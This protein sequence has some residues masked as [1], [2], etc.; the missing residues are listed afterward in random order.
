[1]KKILTLIAVMSM[2]ITLASAQQIK[3]WKNNVCVKQMS[4]SEVDYITFE[5]DTPTTPD[6]YQLS[7]LMGTWMITHSKGTR[8]ENGQVTKS[9]DED[10]ELEFNCLVIDNSKRCIFME[11]SLD[12]DV[13]HEDGVNTFDIVN[14]KPVITS[15]DFSDIEIAS[16]GNG[17]MTLKYAFKDAESNL[18]K[19][20]TDTMKRISQRTDVLKTSTNTDPAR[21]ETL[22][23]L[24]A[25]DLVGTWLI[26]NDKHEDEATDNV[27]DENVESEKNYYVIFSDKLGF[28]EYSNESNSWHLDSGEY[29]KY[30][31]KD[32]KFS[33]PYSY[34]MEYDGANKAKVFVVYVDEKGSNIDT[35]PHIYTLQ[36]VSRNTD[37]ITYRE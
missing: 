19:R 18:I 9:W 35:K 3:F 25:N 7:D 6:S 5:E 37:Y 2:Y 4:A 24:N 14:G 10:V 30:A 11:G 13:W 12:D 21:W 28:I 8:E 15:G 16:Y 1:M 26:T 23:Y 36:R 31:I 20:Y 27:I 34:L 29:Y 22:P 33:M 32:G 17:M